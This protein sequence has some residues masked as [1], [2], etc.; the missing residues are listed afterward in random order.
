MFLFLRLGALAHLVGEMAE[1][2]DD[3]GGAAAA[4]GV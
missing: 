2:L 3:A 4:A 1:R